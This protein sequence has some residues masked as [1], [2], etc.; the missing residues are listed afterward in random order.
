MRGVA[1]LFPP[2]PPPYTRTRTHAWFVP[3]AA[4]RWT[5]WT[6]FDDTAVFDAAP[7]DHE[8]LRKNAVLLFCRRR[9]QHGSV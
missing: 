5:R 6:V 9:Q 1:A 8:V 3:T 7:K 4:R 2:P